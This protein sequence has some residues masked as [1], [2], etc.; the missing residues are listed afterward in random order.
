M[1]DSIEDGVNY[2]VNMDHH[3]EGLMTI[4]DLLQG[5]DPIEH[6]DR[7]TAVEVMIE[8]FARGNEKIKGVIADWI[9]LV[10][11]NP[12]EARTKLRL[13]CHLEPIKTVL[14]EEL[15]HTPT[16]VELMAFLRAVKPRLAQQPINDHNRD[17]FLELYRDHAKAVYA[18]TPITLNPDGSHRDIDQIRKSIGGTIIRDLGVHYVKG[19]ELDDRLWNLVGIAVKRKLDVPPDERAGKGSKWDIA[20]CHA[21]LELSST[22][23]DIRSWVIG[24]LI[25]EGWLQSLVALASGTGIKQLRSA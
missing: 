1:L 8:S 19:K 2:I 18:S 11:S 21:I 23:Q 5:D 12:A 15:N 20:N 13:G 14:Y 24:Q 16:D 6:Q 7:E 17:A 10:R 25:E 4:N 9:S 22:R 3:L